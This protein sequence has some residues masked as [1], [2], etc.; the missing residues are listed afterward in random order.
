MP[1]ARKIRSIRLPIAPPS[2]RP[3]DT[4]QGVDRSRGAIR[5]ITMTTPIATSASSQVIPVAIENAAPGIADQREVD[6]P[7]EHP[8]R[9][10]RGRPWP[11]R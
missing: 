4:A 3:S 8:H 1:G 9:L 11:P 6:Q 7:A 2:T 10:V 5:M